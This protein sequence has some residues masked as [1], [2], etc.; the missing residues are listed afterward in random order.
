MTKAGFP[1]TSGL[2]LRASDVWLEAVADGAGELES[3][4]GEFLAGV[5]GPGRSPH[6]AGGCADGELPLT[7]RQTLQQVLAVGAEVE[8]AGR[9]A[10]A[11]DGRSD[12]G[13]RLGDG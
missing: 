10:D 4:E 8:A 7:D 2:R 11:R 12:C 5:F 6:V 1:R 9:F 3:S 13:H